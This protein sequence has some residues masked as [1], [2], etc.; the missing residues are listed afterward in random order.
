MEQEGVGME[1]RRAVSY[2]GTPTIG[3]E[4]ALSTREA[5]YPREEWHLHREEGEEEQG[6]QILFPALRA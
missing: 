3:Q 1:G 6:Q 2:V 4:N 5:V